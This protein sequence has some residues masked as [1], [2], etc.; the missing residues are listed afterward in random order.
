MFLY[1]SQGYKIEDHPGHHDALMRLREE[2]EIGDFINLPYLGY[3]KEH[4]YDELWHEILTLCETHP[5]TVVYFQYFHHPRNQDPRD[6]MEKLRG[7]PSHPT[8]VSS[9]GDGLSVG[10]LLPYYPASFK[11]CASVSD[12]V[13][14]T[15]MGPASEAIQSWG[16]KYVILL[17]NSMCQVRFFS[18]AIDLPSHQFDFDVSFIG[19]RNT[20]RLPISRN[21]W[22][23]R[24][25]SEL[26]RRLDQR[27][28]KRL[29]LF[30]HGWNGLPS[31]Q[32][33][34]AFKDIQ[35]TFRR[36]RVCVDAN[37]Y[38]QYDY[39]SSNRPFFAIASGVPTVMLSVPRLDTILKPDWHCYY[40]HDVSSV[41]AQCDRLLNS[42]PAG[43]YKQSAQA[44]QDISRRHTQYH[45]MKFL[46]QTCKKYQNNGG[47]L[48]PQSLEFPYFAD[49]VNIENE[50]PHCFL[51]GHK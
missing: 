13:F 40:A 28:G 31:W 11:Q 7:L 45:R 23:G 6:C 41:I 33:P 18:T 22:L 36:G 46:V 2:G 44:A 32:G 43:L 48:S 50:F 29:G 16:A 49:S 10:W 17:P 39:Y 14:S 19:S 12:L 5:I 30:G 20:G 24:E 35:N 9:S 8:L 26:V 47:T 3:A 1:L 27:Y 51:S 21:F 38:S 25:R 34:T 15:Q 4:G 42:D 37:P